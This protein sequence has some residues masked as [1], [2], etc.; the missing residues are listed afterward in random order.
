MTNGYKNIYKLIFTYSSQSS[1]VIVN[2][3]INRIYG[4][5]KSSIVVNLSHICK[6]LMNVK[7]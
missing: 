4:D 7:I 3:K 5:N 1:F 2:V 6:I